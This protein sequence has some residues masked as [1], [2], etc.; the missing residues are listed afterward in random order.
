[1]TYP[2]IKP[3]DIYLPQGQDLTKWAVIAC[4]QYTSQPAYWEEVERVAGDA[5]STLNI[6]QPEV[7]LDNAETRLQNVYASMNEYLE[8]G[9]LTKQVENGFVVTERTTPSG[10]R[11]GLVCAVD[12]ESYDFTP[13]T[14]KMIRATEGTV[15]ERIP[16]RVKIRE[17]APLE[18]PH[19]MVLIDDPACTVVEPLYEA[20]KSTAALYDFEL[21]CRG[22]HLRGWGISGIQPGLKAAL[23]KLL[24][25]NDGFLY[26]VGDG[27]HSLATAKACHKP[28]DESTRYAL[29]EIVNLHC[30]ALSFEPIHRVMFGLSA[31]AALE[32]FKKYLEGRGLS[33]KQGSSIRFTDGTEDSGIDVT[34]AG[35]V[36]DVTLVQPWLDEM[37]YTRITDYIHGEEAVREICKAKNASGILLGSMDKSAL[38]PSVKRNGVLPRKSFSMGEAD[39]KRF[40]MEVKLIK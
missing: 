27:N 25:D 8:K 7:Y 15:L 32:S 28:G 37:D 9:I 38:F 39:E 18:C 13:G 29:V 35:N 31:K 6:V 22:G 33:W 30:P 14:D 17:K 12:L 19:I 34:G 24:S 4:D 3:A 1:M 11:P 21:M 2:G 5:P 26:A 10:I 23:E 20:V 40:Y 16:P 36:L